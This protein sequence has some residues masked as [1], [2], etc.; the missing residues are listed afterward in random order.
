[1]L[2]VM[3]E[4]VAQIRNDALAHVLGQV[5]AA[6]RSEP[7]QYER[8]DDNRGKNAKNADVLVGEN[9]IEDVTNQKRHGTVGGTEDQHAEHGSREERPQIGPQEAE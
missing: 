3:V 4:G 1:M 6:K 7:A 9:V 8:E 2:D 5:R